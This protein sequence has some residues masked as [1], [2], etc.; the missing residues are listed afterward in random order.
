SPEVQ[1]LSDM[2]EAPATEAQPIAA[3]RTGA[4]LDALITGLRGAPHR[5]LAPLAAAVAATPPALWPEVRALLLAPR[6]AR[7]AD[8]KALL[9]VIGGD[10][11]NRYGHF[12]LA[13]KQAHG[14][15]VRLSED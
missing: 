1:D 9:A 14:H 6:S 5:D 2:A 4:E 15:T 8:Y 7:K 12:E 11:P 3:P 13:W 10:V